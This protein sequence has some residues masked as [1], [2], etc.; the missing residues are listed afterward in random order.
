MN[1]NLDNEHMPIDGSID[2]NFDAILTDLE[3]AD[4]WNDLDEEIPAYDASTP[5]FIRRHD[6][7]NILGGAVDV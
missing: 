1:Y 3:G 7:V 6:L 5:D 4:L 2:F